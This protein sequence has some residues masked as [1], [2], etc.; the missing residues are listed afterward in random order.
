MNYSKK[1]IISD[2]LRSL[3]PLKITF[4]NYKIKDPFQEMMDSKENLRDIITDYVLNRMVCK[5]KQTATQH[6]SLFKEKRNKNKYIQIKAKVNIN[7]E[8]K[9]FSFDFQTILE[10]YLEIDERNIYKHLNIEPLIVDILNFLDE[11]DGLVKQMTF[12]FQDYIA[13]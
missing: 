8:E 9:E 10:N 7:G 4:D 1:S 3:K 5:N 11:L 6:K 2:S 12:D 13:D